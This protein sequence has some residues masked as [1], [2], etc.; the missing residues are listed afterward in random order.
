M[1]VINIILNLGV[2]LKNEANGRKLFPK[3]SLDG[4]S[5]VEY[6][7]MDIIK[8]LVTKELTRSC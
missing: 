3:K 6:L 8:C 7:R 2:S 5:K 4:K 1:F